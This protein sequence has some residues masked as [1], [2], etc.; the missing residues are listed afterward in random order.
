MSATPP[1]AESGTPV[2]GDAPAFRGRVVSAVRWQALDQ[3]VQQLL[4]LVVMVVLARLVA[5]E[6]FGIVALALVVTELAALL[7]TLGLGS[8]VVQRRDLTQTHVAVAFTLTS[9]L[10]LLWAG[11]LLVLA[12]A[13]AGFFEEPQ[14]VDVLRVMSIAFVCK[15]VHAV[16]LDLL[17]REL[18]F[19]RVIVMST[20]ATAVAGTGAVVAALLGAGVWAL[21]VFSVGEAAGALV[22]VFVLAMRAG[23][24]RPRLSL[25]RRAGRDMFRFGAQV[26]AVQVLY[27][28]QGNVDN[29]LVGKVLGPGPLGLYSVAYRLMLLPILRVADVVTIVAFPAFSSIQ[30]DT[31]RLSAALQR[32]VRSISLVCFP[33][34]LGTLAAAPLVVGLV[35][36]DRWL[37]AVPVVQVLALNGP[38]LA[39]ARL[40]GAVLL[41]RGLAA[42]NLQISALSFLLYLVGFGVGVLHGIEGVAWGYTVAGH[43]ATPLGLVAAAR[44][45]ETS[46]WSLLRNAVPAL[47]ASTLMAVVAAVTAALVD[48]GL[49][50]PVQL[51]VVVAAAALTYAGVLRVLFPASLAS[52]V[53]DVLRRGGRTADGTTP[54]AGAASP[55]R[56]S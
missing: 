14:L 45:V 46:T 16:P 36:G 20:F 6:D 1:H 17:R 56:P 41:A 48:G 25:D 35:F 9:A 33:L 4:R 7:S 26:S 38:R 44:V 54:P 50:R 29:L 53:S 12:P 5:P 18:L 21:V 55:E 2:P 51:A 11:A 31:A 32:G 27:Y 49:P 42:R 3:G 37:A 8:A 13:V 40:D 28:A 19:S 52:L 23:V 15:G 22:A 43:L 39:V 24:F 30:H 47:V 34:S 10:G